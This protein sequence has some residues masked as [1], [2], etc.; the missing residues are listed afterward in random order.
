MYPSRFAYEAPRTVAIETARKGVSSSA[1]LVG[2]VS[3]TYDGVACELDETASGIQLILPL[4][5][6]KDPRPRVMMHLRF[7]MPESVPERGDFIG[8]DAM[9]L[10]CPAQPVWTATR[11]V[12]SSTCWIPVASS[13]SRPSLTGR[14]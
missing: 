7:T 8:Q 14:T 6:A 12:G 2:E 9:L 5:D 3:F 10:L 4:P 1:T 13:R 11:R